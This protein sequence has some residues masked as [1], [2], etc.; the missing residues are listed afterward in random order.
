[1]N[2]T[3]KLKKVAFLHLLCFFVTTAT[4]QFTTH[5]P[6]YLFQN[7]QIPSNSFYDNF[8]RDLHVDESGFLWIATMNGLF[9]YDGK[10]YKRYVTDLKDKKS[11]SGD[12]H[13]CII[14]DVE[15]GFW[16]SSFTSG[17][18][19]GGNG[20]DYYDPR[21]D[22]FQNIQLDTIRN[23]SPFNYVS[24]LLW[25]ADSTLLWI[26]T[27]GGL[28]TYLPET[29]NIEQFKL[30]G[31]R[32]LTINTLLT[33]KGK[34]NSFWLGTK[35]GLW[36]FEDGTYRKIDLPLLNDHRIN[37]LLWKNDDQ[38]L[39]ACS[40][41]LFEY[42]TQ[43]SF[44]FQYN[45]EIEDS[46][47]YQDA[48]QTAIRGYAKS[49]RSLCQAPNGDIWIGSGLGLFLLDRHTKAVKDYSRYLRTADKFVANPVGALLYVPS[50][51]LWVGKTNGLSKVI[52]AS[53]KVRKYELIFPP[54]LGEQIR[55]INASGTL[56]SEKCEVKCF[57]ANEAD[58]VWVGTSCG[59]FQFDKKQK[60]F[61]QN[62][63]ILD[64]FPFLKEK[65]ITAAFWDRD[66]NFWVGANDYGR[67][68]RLRITNTL[69]RI[70]ADGELMTFSSKSTINP[71]PP[72]AVKSI[73]QD[74]EGFIWITCPKGLARYDPSEQKMEILSSNTTE[75]TLTSNNTR[76]AFEDQAGQIWIGTANG[77]INWYDKSTQKIGNIQS[78]GQA[79]EST[80]SNDRINDITQ[81][82]VD[83]LWVATQ[84]GLNRISLPEKVVSAEFLEADDRKVRVIL[85]H[86]KERLC[87]ATDH[88]L[89]IYSTT[90]SSSYYLSFEDGFDG[91][92][93]IANAGY[94]DD[95]GI[96]YLGGTQFMY[97]V[98]PD[99]DFGRADLRS[100]AFTDFQINGREQ[101]V[102]AIN[103][104]QH[105]SKFRFNDNNLTFQFTAPLHPDLDVLTY[106][107]RL[108]STE[109]WEELGDNNELRFLNLS[110]GSYQLEIA[111]NE[112]QSSAALSFPF[113]IRSPWYWSWWSRIVY[114]S[115][116]LGLIYLLYR[117]QLRR[118]LA[119]AETAQLKQLADFKSQFYTN[120]THEFRT[121]ITV[122]RGL[123]S[124]ITA[125]K[126][127]TDVAILQNNTNWLL[128]L[129]NQFLSLSKL[130]AGVMTVHLE[131]RE[132]IAFLHY[133]T[134]SMRTLAEQKEI[135]LTFE[136]ALEELLMDIDSDKLQHILTNL[137]SNATKF[138]PTSGKV[139]VHVRR[140]E[141]Q[142][143]ISV[144]DN[145]IGIN[146][147]DQEKIFDR[148]FQAK[149]PKH[150]SVGGSG[151]GL[152][153]CKELVE[154]LGGKI[155]V[156]SNEV[157]GSTF[158]FSLPMTQKASL[159]VSHLEAKAINSSLSLQQE[160]KAVN[161][162]AEEEATLLLV[163][164]NADVLYYLMQTLK[165]KYRILKAKNGQEGIDMA[166][167]HLPDLI[168][169]DIMMPI[170]DGY[171]LCIHL[172]KHEITQHLPII[173]LTAKADQSS[174]IEGLKY[175]AD[176]YLMK[177]FDEIELIVRI[178]QLLAKQQ[179]MQRYYQAKYLDIDTTPVKLHKT[180]ENE[181]VQ[182]CK[183]I[184]ETDLQAKWT[185]AI[186]AQQLNLGEPNFRRKIKQL[187]GYPL[188]I[189]VR[190]LR[191][192]KAYELIER[193][194]EPLKTIAHQVG[195][196]SPNEL[197]KYFREV[198]GKSPSELRT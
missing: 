131:Q 83:E 72:K 102:Y 126:Y 136:S 179:M 152:A 145:G 177:P 18:V 56:R 155:G 112:M 185:A 169:S 166:I 114:L 118:R 163:E 52:R 60:Q 97:E 6:D 195:F 2:Q 189:F 133:I 13:T 28:V 47:L 156:Y 123:A 101:N 55:T 23:T 30:D 26:G 161:L 88:H 178:E 168:I 34:E 91:G 95:E 40:Q 174:K 128:H 32:K 100:L 50:G 41:G 73:I 116:I 45:I 54:A 180:E 146:P 21:Q 170:V 14:G 141:E 86:D 49:M 129:V 90:D 87:V 53:Q 39:I 167:E 25:N 143:E 108:S 171:D 137:L 81:L 197:S 7:E 119:E 3:S 43:S 94:R 162:L 183:T 194:N 144:S 127:S 149:K 147:A 65:N 38:L 164:D 191:L 67:V 75:T 20:I 142:L 117:F 17:S 62:H 193:T 150:L 82:N 57:T 159:A 64:A 104:Q 105:L 79:G 134:E 121:P 36:M 71:I 148:Y 70:G 172:K 184:I 33:R 192:K 84:L 44:L 16:V 89:L 120:I 48:P 125:K 92:R 175:G 99:F 196:G 80:L 78:I 61:F 74:R 63:T 42:D 35:K 165:G 124:K 37:D 107:Y 181:L 113:T 4:A 140:K 115:S 190:R 157:R 188:T 10:E 24:D 153:V 58:F 109:G 11:I 51:T 154:L 46:P 103:H 93:F 29:K 27:D 135:K 173:L 69:Y 106:R 187:S 22:I 96:I 9:R 132:V 151:I 98:M 85:P 66:G 19:R 186:L 8:I 110:P 1:M 77:G 111:A 139:K 160:L 158:Y 5:S 59:L 138:T 122:I 182:Q 130:E 31:N 176:A 15:S 198:F 68:P 12:G 76:V